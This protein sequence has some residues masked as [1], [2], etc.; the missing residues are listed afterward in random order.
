MVSKVSTV[1]FQ[2]I[3]VKTIDV[4]T[5]MAGGL[6]AFTIVGLPDKA[7]AES[8]E[9]VR[10]ALH[11]LG[12]SLPAKR[13]T[14]NLAPADISKEGSHYDLPIALGL[15][16]A[17]D[18]LPQDQLENFFVL[19]ELGLDGS[20][21]RVNGIL[22]AALHA[23]SLN[24]G[25]ICP[26][27]CG[28]EALWAGSDDILA[29]ADLLH[30]INHMKGTQLLRAPEKSIADTK[31]TDH[32]YPD[33]SVVKGQ[34]SAKRA[35]EI[36]AAGGH[37]LLL[38]GPPGSGKSL[39]ASCLPGLLP[40]LSP[41][42]ALEISMIHSV[43]GLLPES[44]LIRHRPLR[45]PHHSS[46]LVSLV[47]GG[48]KIKPGEISLAHHGVL[49]LDELPEFN[50]ATL[51]A[52]RQPIET[53]EVL[54]SRASG[55]V[56]YPAQFQLVAAMNPCRCGFLGDP[57]QECTRAPK[58]GQDYQSKLSGPLL[59]RMDIRLDVQPVPMSDITD[60]TNTG[61]SSAIV[62]ARIEAAREIQ[63][64]R[65]RALNLDQQLQK[66]NARLPVEVLNERITL[67]PDAK[68]FLS[69]AMD[70]L[71]L[72]A[73][74][75]HRLLKVAQT[76]HDLDPNTASDIFSEISGNAMA[77]ALSYRGVISE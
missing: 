65:F 12:L 50:R 11:A 9:R 75:Y 39:L 26:K 43:A 40:T 41:Q 52:L 35:L 16:A 58:C 45:D 56:R 48:Q 62:A 14:V 6:P 22:P 25:L 61:E 44:G 34:E 31:N 27:D 28:S 55:H 5:Q 8:R 69:I 51:E 76:I 10:A 47:G 30:I 19:G 57:T 3:D 60:K 18:I 36:T 49:F 29:P 42:E 23:A 15:L 46:S 70:R 63:K 74:G 67:S 21:R 37:N 77:E 17:M 38:S 53:G 68:S 24:K 20:I 13:V 72:S 54:I 59:D 64:Q 73:R 4:E 7:I 71:K 1:S 2:G 33:L 66:T 32:S